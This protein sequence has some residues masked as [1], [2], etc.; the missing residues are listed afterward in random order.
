MLGRGGMGVVYRAFDLQLQRDVAIKMLLNRSLATK[1]E[2]SQ[3]RQEA[4]TVAACNTP[5]IIQ[6]FQVGVYEGQLFLV[7]EYA[8]YGSLAKKFAGQPLETQS[9]CRTLGRYFSSN[10]CNS[11]MVSCTA[12]SSHRTYSSLSQIR[13]RSQTLA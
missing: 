12:I 4:S 2:Q 10:R 11:S 3:F 6:V 9:C 1:Q 5:Q 8:A 13:S 7:L